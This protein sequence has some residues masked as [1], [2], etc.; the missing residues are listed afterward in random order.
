MVGKF[1]VLTGV[2]YAI[3]GL[4]HQDRRAAVNQDVIG[5]GRVIVLAAEGGRGV[6]AFKAVIVNVQASAPV[7]TRYVEANPRIGRYFCGSKRVRGRA[8]AGVVVAGEIT[9][10]S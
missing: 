10:R 4:H 9:N 5:A 2:E 6:V 1:L 7:R 8:A 3:V